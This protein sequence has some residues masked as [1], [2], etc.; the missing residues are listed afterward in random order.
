MPKPV[1]ITFAAPVGASKTPIA[2]YLSWNLGLPMWNNDAVRSEIAED[3]GSWTQEELLRR[4]KERIPRLLAS[5]RSFIGDVSI[6][7]AWSTYAPWFEQAGYDVCVIF[8][9]LARD[10][11]ERMYQAKGYHD[12]L[13]RL[14]EFIEDH[15]SFVEKHTALCAIRVTEKEFSDRL[16]FV[17]Q[18]VKRWLASRESS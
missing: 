17:L 2:T 5:Q 14:D 4:C 10:H 18:E 6:D 9:D 3:M 7:R 15:R 16:E 1:C 12:S 11:L 8:I 13:L